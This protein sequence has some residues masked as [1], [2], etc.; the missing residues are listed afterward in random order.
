MFDERDEYGG[1]DLESGSTV[2]G[3]VRVDH[4]AALSTL[5][6]AAAVAV[7]FWDTLPGD[8]LV[9]WSAAA[10][11]LTI[12]Q[13]QASRWPLPSRRKP[14]DGIG[15]RLV[16]LSLGAGSF[17]GIA[18]LAL[19]PAGSLP[20]QALLAV[21]LISVTALWLP[22]FAIAPR[23]FWLFALPA[24][25]PMVYALLTSPPSSQATMGSLLLALLAAVV[26]LAIVTRTIHRVLRAGA[27]ARRSLYHQATHDALVGLVNRGEFDRRMR[28]LDASGS[29]YALLFI[30]LDHFKQVND[31]AGHAVGDELLRHVAAVLSDVVRRGDTAARLGGDEFA[32]VMRDCQAHDATRV[33]ATILE[34]IAGLVIRTDSGTCRVTAS[35]GIACSA[36]AQ[37]SAART[38]AA[39]DR[40][41]YVAKHGG[42][43]RFAVAG[44]GERAE[45]AADRTASALATHAST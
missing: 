42:R 39:A 8:V 28:V 14:R 40:A 43:N 1:A 5:V 19:A 35:L 41:C 27:T 44:G 25:L 37:D 15:L 22:V 32:I 36:R 26:V 45:R 11:A 13:W 7:C 20:H 12:L 10:V 21:V 9:A 4:V 34:R 3:G 33:A 2:M 18:G 6:G 17:W 38:L 24:V 16:A 29:Q 30:D 31:T 23:I